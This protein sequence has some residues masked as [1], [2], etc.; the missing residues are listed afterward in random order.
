VIEKVIRKVAQDSNSIEIV[1]QMPGRGDRLRP[2][3]NRTAPRLKEQN[4]KDGTPTVEQ[5]KIKGNRLIIQSSIKVQGGAL[6]G[7]PI[8]KTQKW[9]LSKD[10]KTL[11]V[12]E[13]FQIQ[14][15]AHMVGDLVTITCT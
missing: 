14:A 7:I 8:T 2:S 10:L 9:E 12:S 15:R 11:T 1:F 5:A 13:E 4:R 3:T 6:K